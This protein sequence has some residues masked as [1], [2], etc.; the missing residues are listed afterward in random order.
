MRPTPGPAGLVSFD[1]HAD[2]AAFLEHL[3]E[4]YGDVVRYQTRQRPCFVFVRPEHVQAVL[5]GE[6]YR[7]ASLVRM[8]LGDGL[9][10][11]D[12][13]RWRS[14]R[15]LMQPDFFADSVAPIASIIAAQT[16]RLAV[17]WR[18]S[19]FAS[20]AVDVSSDMTVL[21]LRVIV[22]ALFSE[23][24]SDARAAELCAAVTRTIDEPGR[25]SWSVFGA[26]VFMTPA[27][28]AS[29]TA[30]KK[31]IDAFCYDLIARRRAMTPQGRPRDLLTMLVE[32]PTP[33]GPMTDLQLRDEIVTMLV[34]GHETTAL[35]LAWTWK[36]LAGERAILAAL[37][38]EADAVLAGRPPELAD[39]ARLPYA[40]AVFSETMRLYPPVWY[41]SRIAQEDDSIGG[42][43]IPRG[44][45]VM[46]SQWL[47]HRRAEFW[48]EPARFDPGRFIDPTSPRHRYAYFPF[49]G[50]RHQCLGMHLAL[51][52][53]TMILAQ[54][55]QEFVVHPINADEIKHEWS[56][57]LRQSPGLRATIALRPSIKSREA[58]PSSLPAQIQSGTAHLPTTK[59]GTT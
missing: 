50:G 32:A 54:L 56:I 23:E 58:K 3:V 30:G 9:L 1:P 13:P 40:R 22:A 14:Q 46:V 37:Q 39:V 19:A 36:T 33:D 26:A 10:A 53:G 29:F 35:S 57:T 17:A 27:G 45:C 55:A 24:L 16:T 8:T 34:G 52:E 15:R 42:H 51:M 20:D 28:T 38:R 48:P 47:T 49:G 31:A 6:N 7:R 25:L 4:Q 2:P 41:I 11:S 12:G 44:A 21:T 59:P 5:H 43:A 18:Q